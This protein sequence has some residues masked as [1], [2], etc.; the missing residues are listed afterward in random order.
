MVTVSRLRYWF[1]LAAIAVIVVVAGFYVYSRYR[2]FSAV[3]DVPAKLGV[4]IQQSTDTFSLSKS[5]GGRTLFTIRASKAVQ[6]KQGGRAELHD[7]NIVVYGRESNRFDQIYGD[8]FEYDPQTGNVVAKGVVHID[9]EANPGSDLH[10]ELGPPQELKNPIHLKT[11]GLVFNQKSGIAKT[12]EPIEFRIP[13]ASGSAH[14]A[15]YDSKASTLTLASDIRVQTTGPRAMNLAASHGVITKDPRR[16]VLAN[17]KVE[18][19]DDTMLAN[20]ATLFLRDDNT[21]DRILAE[22]DVQTSA[23]GETSMETHSPR[24]EFFMTAKGQILTAIMSGGVSLDSTG[25][26]HMTG[27]AGRLLADFGPDAKLDKVYAS[28]GVKLFQAPGSSAAVLA[29]V[30]RSPQLVLA[31]AQRHTA[32]TS[33]SDSVELFAQAINFYVKGGRLLERAETE[34]PGQITITPQGAQSGAA[35]T[36]ITATKFTAVF[37]KTR[38]SGVHGAPNARVVQSTPGQG[39]RITTSSAL[40]ATFDKSGNISGFVQQGNFQYHEGEPGAKVSRAASAGKAAYNTATQVLTLEGSPRVIDS[41]MTTTAQLIRLNRRT[42][43]AEAQSDVKT[44]YSELKPQPNRALLASA[45]PVHVTAS[46]MLF[47][48]ATEVAHYTGNAR[49]WQGANIVQAPS[50]TFNRE[51]RSMDARGSSNQPVNTVLVEQDKK[52]KVTPVNVSAARLSYTDQQR[53]VRFEGGV[54]IRTGD[55]TVSANHVTVFL[56]ATGTETAKSALPSSTPSAL[57]HIIAE[58]DVVLRE[59][60]RHGTGDKLVYTADDGK[61]VLTG[62]PPRISDATQGTVT[63]SSLTFYSHD[64]RVLVEGGGT[65]RVVTTTRV[66][67]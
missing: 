33:P 6:F 65:T 1:A 53:R 20:K 18:R 28:G 54:T 36:V 51:T 9:L 21:L 66:S 27:T 41:G 40:D 49:L 67:K 29:R 44:T 58:G 12:D 17:V 57:D 38:L 10:P 47:S 15:T 7:V 4:E 34:G 22:G 46:R 30:N 25:T 50:L 45:D 5:E 2:F 37:D 8:Q 19:N 35:T 63:G 16:A 48:R 32:A 43:D 56:K 31:K 24:A 3:K 60:S 55:D 23:K 64:D 13:Q 14:G 62:G 59:P 61:F 11:S 39:D 42:G 26:N 52:G